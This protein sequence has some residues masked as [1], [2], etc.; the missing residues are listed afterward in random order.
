MLKKG[1]PVRN[2][3]FKLFI[4]IQFISNE[5]FFIGPGRLNN[6][7]GPGKAMNWFPTYTT[8]RRNKNVNDRYNNYY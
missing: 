4:M 6:I 2:L 8:T 3:K 5:N 7:I 1:A